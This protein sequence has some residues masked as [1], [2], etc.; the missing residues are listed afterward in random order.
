MKIL[1]SISF[2]FVSILVSSCSNVSN[3]KI[4]DF[5]ETESNSSYN[6]TEDAEQ[7]KINWQFINVK[8]QV[9]KVPKNNEPQK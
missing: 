8:S 5:N 6:K 1:V 3:Q 4:N 9:Q 7:K 2:L